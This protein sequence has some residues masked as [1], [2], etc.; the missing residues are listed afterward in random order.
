[1]TTHTLTI[2]TSDF[3]IGVIAGGRVVIDRK[4]SVAAD[5][6]PAVNALYTVTA[7]TDD[8]GIATAAL[9]ADDSSTYHF[10]RIYN[11]S[12]VAVYQSVFAMSPANSD[13]I[14]LPDASLTGA[15]AVAAQEARDAAAASATTASEHSTSAGLI[16]AATALDRI[17]TAAD[18]VQT[19]LDVVAAGESATTATTQADNAALSASESAASAA[20]ASLSADAALLSAGSIYATTA[21]GIAATSSGQYFYVV[22]SSTADALDLY[23]NSA[24]SAVY[25]KSVPASDVVNKPLWVGRKNAYPDPFFRR[26]SLTTKLQLGRNRWW[27]SIGG[28]VFG[29]WSLVA[30]TTFDGQALRRTANSGT[31]PLNGPL[32]YLDEISAVA[33]DTITLYALIV[34][35]GAVVNMPG[36][37]DGGTDA[38]YV[39]GQVNPVNSAGGA[40]VTASATPQWLRITTTV[41]ATATRFV[42]YPY[43][44]TA[45]KTFDLVAMWGWRGAATAGPAWPQFMDDEALSLRCDGLLVA[46]AAILAQM[47]IEK[48]VD[49]V[50]YMLLKTTSITA[51]ATSTPLDVT[52]ASLTTSWGTPFSGWGERYTPAGITFNAVQVAYIGRKTSTLVDANRWRSINVV[53][54]T[55]ANSHQASSAVVAVGSVLVNPDSDTLTNVSILLRDP[56]TNALKTLTD[57]DFTGGEYFVGIYARSVTGG[58]ADISDHR[59]TQS[60]SAGQSYYLTTANPLSGAWVAYTAN[61]RV[62]VRHLLLTSPVEGFDYAP[63]SEFTDQIP[64]PAPDLPVPT[65]ALPPKF[66]LLAG[67]EVSLYF[68]NVLPDAAA[69]YEWDVSGLSLG[70]HQNERWTTNPSGA[71]SATT[72]TVSAIR[73]VDAV[74]VASGTTSVVGVA[75]SA[76]SGTTKNCLFIGDSLTQADVMTQTLLDIAGSDV[77]G[78]TLL[79]TRGSGSNKHE[80]RG[81]WT[82]SDYATAGRTFYSFTVSGV[83]VSPQINS[84]EY[85]NNSSTFRVQEVSLS[86]GS[87]TITCE[88]VAGSN[89]PS[90]SGTLTKTT[91]TGDATITFS[92]SSTVSGNP[93]WISGALNFPQY[94]TNN[95]LA[96][97]DWVFIMLGTNDVFSYTSD[98]AAASAADGAFSTLDT[99]ITSIKAAGAGVNVVLI[100]PPCPS[101]DQDAFGSSYGAGQTRWRFKRNIVKWCGQ[102]YTKYTG[103][104]ASRI[105]ICPATL[106]LDT[107]NNMQRAASATVNSRTAV[108]SERQNNG[109]HPA[110]SGYQQIA[111]GVW[112]FLKNQ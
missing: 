26:A 14:D 61:L 45:G 92:A 73:R 48:R 31:T 6:Y 93:F 8:N 13:L 50:D 27:S 25:Q 103:Q 57:S 16:A 9:K 33:G 44:S 78:V 59:A 96:T 111:D 72:V 66:Y 67:R 34:G 87:G 5:Q 3:G 64:V 40:S 19:G 86:G 107:T 22:S 38:V 69:D 83:T 39:G 36:R 52:S 54:R 109:V 88:R 62:G 100:P 23:L 85:T 74:T 75:A 99:L 53:I 95:S 20:A 37:F 106:N 41:P 80:G 24:G 58:V 81:G 46:D 108:T 28:N 43:T 71:Q 110:T 89:A 105:Y 63:R 65:L 1:M 94:L 10:I 104:E 79:G 70:Q 7:E 55:G 56:T 2:T 35:D 101:R 18:R 30:N 102:L 49:E 12:G 91:G 60:N 84:T 17:A 42:V 21:A 97:P 112:A 82:I 76:N 15:D 29:S 47:A 32:I 68:D 4:R 11:T 98:T 90:A 77:M 51:S